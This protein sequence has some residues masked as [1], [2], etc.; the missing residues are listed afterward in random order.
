M[1]TP[2]VDL[3][4]GVVGSQPPPPQTKPNDGDPLSLSSGVVGTTEDPATPS[5][6]DATLEN[7]QFLHPMRTVDPANP[8]SVPNA[9]MRNLA[10]PDDP[11][12]SLAE[13][14]LDGANTGA[15][16]DAPL[17]LLSAHAALTQG[18]KALVPALT[19]GVQQIGEWATA[20][21]MA[22]KALYHGIRAAIAGAGYGAA[23]K[24]LGKVIDSAPD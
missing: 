6:S 8:A 23:A 5:G 10:R 4:S 2:A 15:L 16:A 3:S 21:P 12:R 11:S 9:R 20:H 13:N 18:F 14:F 24:I 22:A 1:S 19:G 17:D 7:S